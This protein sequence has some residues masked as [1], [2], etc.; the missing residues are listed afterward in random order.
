[1]ASTAAVIRQEHGL[2]HQTTQ[3]LDRPCARRRRPASDQDVQTAPRWFRAVPQGRKS[4]HG[5]QNRSVY[6]GLAWHARGH[7]EPGPWSWRDIQNVL[8][9]GLQ[10]RPEEWVVLRT[11]FRFRSVLLVLDRR[12]RN[13]SEHSYV[14]K[15]SRESEVKIHWNVGKPWVLRLL[16]ARICTSVFICRGISSRI[17]CGC[18]FTIWYFNAC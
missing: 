3:V 1:M 10:L 5:A 7:W 2:C 14:S 11:C 15:L 17:S 13:V 4:V 18:V 12:Q 16:M 6:R 9:Y 8:F